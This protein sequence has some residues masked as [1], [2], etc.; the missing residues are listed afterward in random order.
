M[1]G[2]HT[3]TVQKDNNMHGLVRVHSYAISVGLARTIY[4]RCTYSIFGKKI[5]KYAVIYVV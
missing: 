5:T 2:V 1:C 3:V 4:I